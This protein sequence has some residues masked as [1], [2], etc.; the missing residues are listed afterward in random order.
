MQFDATAYKATTLR[1]WDE[2]AEAWHRWGPDAGVVAGRGDRGDA[3]RGRRAGR[4]RGCSTSRPAP[5]VRASRRPG[6][7]G[8][9]GSV[10]LTDLSAEILTY[11]A[12][13]GR[14]GRP[15]QVSTAAVD[16]EEIGDRWPDT[17]TPPSA[18]SV[19]ST[20]PTSSARCG[21]S[22]RACARA[23]GSRRSSTRGRPQRVLLRAG[24]AIVRRRAG[25]A[26]PAARAAGP[27]QP[28]RPR[29]RP[30]SP[31]A[32]G[33]PRRHRPH[34]DARRCGCR[35]PPEC[36]RF[37]RESFGA[38]H[39]MLSGARRGP[40]RAGLGR[41]RRGARGVRGRR[42]LRRPLRAARAGGRPVNGGS[43]SRRCRRR[44]SCS[45]GRRR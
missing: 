42:R 36:V 43:P 9:S 4:A 24:L 34:D 17:S 8:R 21:A 44:T 41:D 20:S 40:A 7:P 28:G 1:Q 22:G 37:E 3:R 10:L 29:G 32:G 12:A 15:R 16:G 2:A 39:Q 31:R 25:L 6:A 38:L 14:R 45:T 5:A 13:R 19:S 26:A 18:G 30:R 35:R 23:A 33:L 27:L 11:A